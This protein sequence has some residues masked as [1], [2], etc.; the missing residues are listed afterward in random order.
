LAEVAPRLDDEGTPLR[1]VIRTLL[2]PE[3]IN[4]HIKIIDF[5]VGKSIYHESHDVK[6]NQIL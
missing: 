3:T 6:V 2:L 1:E 5:G 4:P